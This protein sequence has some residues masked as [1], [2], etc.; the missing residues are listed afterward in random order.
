MP[1]GVKLSSYTGSLTITKAGTVIDAKQVRGRLV[2]AAANVVIKNSKIL[3]GI[4]SDRSS[5]SV[6]VVDSEIDGGT[7]S[8][9]AIGYRNITVQRSE[10]T[11]GQ[12]SVNCGTNCVIEDSWLH[13]QHLPADESWHVNAF[14]SNGGDNVVLRGNTVQCTPEDNRVEGGC[15]ADVSF[16]GDFSAITNVVVD[17]NLFKA[18]TGGYCGTFGYNAAKPYGKGATNIVVTD[19]VF[20]KGPRGKCGVWGPVTSVPSEAVFTGNRW[21]DGTTI[22]R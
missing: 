3:G 13:D 11:G 2:I 4:D 1:A 7:G 21:V 15:T 16:F 8:A 22:S 17:A 12:H 14:I 5:A 18:T 19:N 6:T 10:I 20:E 9:A